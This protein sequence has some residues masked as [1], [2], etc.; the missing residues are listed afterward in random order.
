MSGY[1]GMVRDDGHRFDVSV[2]E[3]FLFEPSESN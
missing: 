1:Y 3:F 2:G